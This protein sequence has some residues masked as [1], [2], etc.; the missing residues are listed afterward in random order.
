[1]P[2][3]RL[4]EQVGVG[5]LVSFAQPPRELQ[6]GLLAAKSLDN[7]ASLAAVTVCLEAL[8]GR[9]HAWDLLAVATVQ[10]EIGL[11]GAAGAAFSLAPEL[12]VAVDV[13]W[14]TDANTREFGYRTFAL[15]GGPTLA[16]GPNIHHGLFQA[17][18]AAAERA[19]VP[20]ALEPI[21][22][23]HSGT[24]A[25]AMQIARAGIPTAIV[26]IPLRNMHTPV[27]IV[28]LKDIQRTGRLLAEFVAGLPGD[29]LET[30][31]WE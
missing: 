23:G 13:T 21:W 22:A 4:A 2:A 28:S 6:N 10:E 15:G 24:D 11:Q 25:A 29:F 12:A 1:L 17:L 5:S 9:A 18:K 7:R 19:E 26:S 16:I 27:E 20:V 30:L 8:Q 31:S 3:K 14:G